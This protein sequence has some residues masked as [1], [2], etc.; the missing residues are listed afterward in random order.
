MAE[1]PPLPCVRTRRRRRGTPLCCGSPELPAGEAR[2]GQARRLSAP[3]FP[4]EHASARKAADSR[5]RG[6]GPA[7]NVPGLYGAQAGGREGGGG[8]AAGG[9]SLFPASGAHLPSGRDFYVPRVWGVHRPPQLSCHSRRRLQPIRSAPSFIIF[10]LNILS[11]AVRNYFSPPL[12]AAVVPR[13]H[14]GGPEPR[15][16]PGAQASLGGGARSTPAVTGP[17][18]R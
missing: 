3:P 5:R 13:P 18:G 12:L 7:A 10:H 11:K 14:P 2:C 15:Q 1:G 17:F 16:S 9:D 6:P 8:R 4:G